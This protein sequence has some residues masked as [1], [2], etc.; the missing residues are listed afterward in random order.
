MTVN[1]T[2]QQLRAQ[3]GDEIVSCSQLCYTLIM[4]AHERPMTKQEAIVG[5]VH[6]WCQDRPV[7]LCVLFGS[8]VAGKPH[9]KSDIDLAVWR[10]LETSLGQAVSLV[11][12]SSDLDPVLGLEISRRGLPIFEAEPGLWA[13]R[14]AQLWHA[15]NDSLP[16]RRAA[17]QQLQEYAEDLRRDK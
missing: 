13:E 7:A 9:P 14:R 3:H 16:F 12:V 1:V 2:A 8:Q 4:T 10:E 5:L 15:Y 11:L 17:R 6:R